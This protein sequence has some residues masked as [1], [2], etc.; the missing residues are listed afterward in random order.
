MFGTLDDFDALIETAH[1]LGIKVMIDL[2]LSHTS[3][4]ASLV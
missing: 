3:D 2:V 1:N 4:E